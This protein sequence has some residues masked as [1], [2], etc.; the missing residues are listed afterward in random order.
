M[1][2]DRCANLDV[3]AGRGE[4]LGALNDRYVKGSWCFLG[5]VGVKV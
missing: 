3:R 5:G 1:A 4:Q 2:M